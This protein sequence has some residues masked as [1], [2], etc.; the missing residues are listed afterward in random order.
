[1]QFVH[2][3]TYEQW[4]RQARE[5]LV[6]GVPPRDVHFSTVDEQ[7]SLFDTATTLPASDEIPKAKEALKLNV[8]KA[9]L[10]LAET[11]ACHRDPRRWE[12]LYRAVWRLT[13]GEPQLLQIS[14]DDDTHALQQMHKAVTRD[15]H[16]MKAF[17]RFRKVHDASTQADS[18]VAWHRPDHRIV[19]LAA[20][21]FAR[22]FRGMCWTILTPHE[23]VCW[24]QHQLR[25]GDGVPADEAPQGDALEE[26]WKTYYASIFN[27][28][29][30]KVAMMK[31]E[32][33]VRHWPTMPE[34]ELIADLLA[35][36]PTRVSGMIDR[37]E[38]FEQ[39]A[40]HFMPEERTLESLQTAAEGCRAC[41]LHRCASRTVFGEGPSTARLVIVGEQPGDQEDLSGK[42]FVGPAGQLLD[43]A[44][45]QA[46]LNRQQVYVTNVVKHFKFTTRG[47]RR[48]HAKPNSREIFA[49]RPWLEAE[50]AAVQPQAIVCLGVTPAQALLGRDFR[51]TQNRGR[52]LHTEWSRR[53]VATWHPAAI[54]RMPDPARSAQMQSQ[55]V[56]DLVLAASPTD[57]RHE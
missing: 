19:R 57:V 20:P 34:T 43:Q 14:I 1:M 21:F 29:R 22:R 38:G 18:Y 10:A 13:H 17:V 28:A 35:E 50:L 4:R 32:M 11:V 6:A 45:S 44:L 37:R 55:L 23:S 56:D 12:I 5:L 51:L 15:V 9:F 3:E 2:V 16:K 7:P 40:A 41:D 49:C 30:V 33:P 47:K 25:Y 27:P 48:L 8:P 42:P 39:T 31:R 54:L 46:G 26:L 36:A 24:D 53:T 52:I